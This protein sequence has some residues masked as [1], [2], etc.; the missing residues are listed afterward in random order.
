MDYILGDVQH[1]AI[2]VQDF[3]WVKG[4][5]LVL[6][7]Y[8]AVYT[9]AGHYV[10]CLENESFFGQEI[11][12]I[13][14]FQGRLSARSSVLGWIRLAIIEHRSLT[15]QGHT[16]IAERGINSSTAF[17]IPMVNSVGGAVVA[18]PR[19]VKLP[20][21]F[22]LRVIIMVQQLKN[23]L[24]FTCARNKH[25][26]NK[27]LSFFQPCDCNEK[28]KHIYKSVNALRPFPHWRTNDA[29]QDVGSRARSDCARLLLCLSPH[30]G[31]KSN[32][33]SNRV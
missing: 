15:P 20:P 24:N 9:L 14:V 5:F 18:I 7:T 29:D 19:R 22:T 3:L 11:P 12:Q 4:L 16:A 1:I 28:I 21:F 32:R 25:G 2:H 17:H 23:V 10:S 31:R 8:I 30:S 26:K 33:E 13:M 27:Y 6:S